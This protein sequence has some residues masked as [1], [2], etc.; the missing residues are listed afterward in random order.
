M[1]IPNPLPPFFL[2]PVRSRQVK[3]E[4]FK[5][6][7]FIPDEIFKIECCEGLLLHVCERTSF[8]R[9][10]KNTDMKNINIPILRNIQR[11]RNQGDKQVGVLINGEEMQFRAE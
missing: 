1:K 10:T 9:K 7:L 6:S 3:K 2:F 8:S 4:F 5:Y 11:S